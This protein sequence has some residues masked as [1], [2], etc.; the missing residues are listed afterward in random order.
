MAKTKDK[1]VTVT[2]ANEYLFSASG[3]NAIY[4]KGITQDNIDTSSFKIVGNNL[5]FKTSDSKTFTVSNY[6]G[7]KYIKTDAGNKTSLLDI[8]SNNL[9]DNTANPIST[10]S[11][12][13]KRLATGTNYNDKFDFYDY[14]LSTEDKLANKGLVINGGK[15]SDIITGTRYKDTITGGAG[16]NTIL[17]SLNPEKK[18]G[19]DTVVLTK[20]ENLRLMLDVDIEDLDYSANY[21]LSE[22]LWVKNSGNDAI[23]EVY[24]ERYDSSGPKGD[25]VGSI[26]IKN[27]FKKD[28][29]TNTGSFVL[30]DKNGTQITDLRGYRLSKDVYMDSESGH[31]NKTSYTGTWTNDYVDAEGFKLY[32]NGKKTTTDSSKGEEITTETAGY[33]K[34]KGVTM[35]L[36]GSVD[37]NEAYGSKYADTIIG[38]ANDDYIYAGKGNDKITGG[39]GNNYI[40]YQRGDGN[41]VI[42]LTKGEKINLHV[43]DESWNTLSVDKLDFQYAN[44]NKDMIIY[45]LDDSGNKTGSITLKNFG[46]KDV[47]GSN[48]SVKL[49]AEVNGY[50]TN[51]DLKTDE[52][53][54]LMSQATL[55]ANIYK[56][57][58]SKN[59]T[60]TWLAEYID[61]RDAEL[62]KTVGKGKNKQI[63]AKEETDKGLTLKGGAGND[64]IHG[65]KYSDKLYGGAD[66]DKI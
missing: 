66:N 45:V 56:T 41:D 50:N 34:V 37:E 25:L 60:G 5:I 28:V 47:V 22:H 24:T 2:D 18:F 43:Y 55:R 53:F 65:S 17:I 57:E 40:D 44:K 4:V 20:G 27:Y 31:Y 3:K 21:N 61:A 48:G 52:F 10:L 23:I 39:K 13:K 38:G 14:P 64:I 30:L 6:T 59:F 62:T 11:N 12:Q 33:E 49:Y 26:T 9:V 63:V 16:Q 15:G 32:K 35:K 19:N 42:T 58:T 29:L 7:I 54:N 36:G 51:I 8:I 46:K 1:V